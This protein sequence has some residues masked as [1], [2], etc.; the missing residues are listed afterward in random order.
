[1]LF[2][3]LFVP[4]RLEEA[5]SEIA[6]I[7]AM[8]DAEAALA[9]AEA[10]AGVIPASA[11]E[12]IARC[13]AAERF[14]AASI[15][16]EA[17]QTGNP[18]EP[19]VRA[20]RKA[21]PEEAARHVHYGATSQDI[22]DTASMLIA[23]RALEIVEDDL[24]QLAGHCA[25]LAGEHRDTLIVG[26]TL[27]QHALPITFG[28]KAA[29]WLNGVTRARAGLWRLHDDCLAAELGGAAGTLAPLGGAGDAV[30]HEFARLLQLAEPA[31]PWHT[32]RTRVAEIAAALGR[33]AGAL[34]KIALDIALL[35]QT[36]VG[37]VAEGG[38][39]RRGGSSTMPQKRNPVGSVLVRACARQ[40]QGNVEILVR[41]MGQEH[42][43]AAGAWHAEWQA[44]AGALAFTG[45][46]AA[47]LAEVMEGLEVHPERMRENLDATRGLVM[48]ERVSL[49]LAERMGR[50][51][52]HELIRLLS[53][54][55][56]RDSGTLHEAL[57][58]D[59]DVLRHLTVEQIED[60]M[61]P[62]TYL[63][64]TQ[65]FIHRALALHAHR[66]GNGR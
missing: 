38:E 64:S 62:A 44:L 24:A 41:A 4:S 47:W 18:A 7:Q 17:R 61:N 63:G 34:D 26:R 12:E 45:G 15:G 33:T 65:S 10:S 59:G 43:R 49:L 37:E 57:L 50:D 31:L 53:R 32:E 60:V 25:R 5:V 6:W 14:D 54:R 30:L 13:C 29:Q 46:A 66:R 56:E 27:L 52:A 55:I 20:L 39:G 21:V 51:E 58:A 2:S 42:E 23:R 22:L 11:A 36:E 28:L 16:V 3:P 8:L 40:A 48:A 9:R 1:M 19:L 35:S